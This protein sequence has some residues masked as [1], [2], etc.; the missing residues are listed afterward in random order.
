VAID[1]VGVAI[2]RLLGTT[3]EVNRGS[4]FEQEQIARAAELGLGVS[5]PAQINLVTDDEES[6]AFA[7]KVSDILLEG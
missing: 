7:G 6:A 1:A 3:K 5:S 2:L 4:I